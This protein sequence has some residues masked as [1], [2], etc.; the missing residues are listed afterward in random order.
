MLTE[1]SFGWTSLLP[2]LFFFTFGAPNLYDGLGQ[3]APWGSSEGSYGE[4]LSTRPLDDI[5]ILAVE[6]FG[7]GPFGT[8]HLADL[9]AEVIK[10]EDPRVGG[11]VGRYI[12][13]YQEGEDSLF[14]E[15][16]NRNKKSLS[17]DLS[18]PAGREV[19]ED[20]VRK[21]DVVYSNLRGDVPAKLGILYDDLKHLNPRIVCVSVTGYGMS[22]DL[23]RQPGYDYMLQGLAGWMTMTGEPDAPP[24]KTGISLVD[25]CGGFVSAIALLAAVHGARRTGVGTDCDI[26]LY[27]VAISLLTY[28]AAWHLN[29]GW[30]PERISRSAHPA[31]VPFQLFQGSDGDWFLAGCAKEKFFALLAQ[32]IGRPE[33]ATDHRFTTFPKRRVHK[34]ELIAILDRIFATRPASEWVRILREKGVPTAPILDMPD[35]LEASH[36]L[37]RRLRVKTLHHLWGEIETTASPVR[38]GDPDQISYRAAPRRGEHFEPIVT[39]ILGYSNSR[40][41]ELAAAGAF[42]EKVGTEE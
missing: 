29:R 35:A 4:E 6:Q 16:F 26:S 12:S 3:P 5:R 13:P 9:G 33:L 34:D 39:E 41:D 15:T 30:L 2:C 24:T 31:L 28:P 40:V 7:A 27:D 10:I 36:T 25:Y 11:D 23:T 37:D 1:F 17:L 19:F 18:K 38:V 32:A 20:L 8:L 14:F 21:S 22:G 42:G